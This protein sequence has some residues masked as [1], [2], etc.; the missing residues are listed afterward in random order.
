M[1]NF[2]TFSTHPG[3][4][5]CWIIRLHELIGLGD[6]A[7]LAGD[8]VPVIDQGFLIV[9]PN[10]GDGKSLVVAQLASGCSECSEMQVREMAIVLH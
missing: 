6:M 7:A 3:A 5:Q 9:L 2:F 10:F 1:A 4:H 8:F